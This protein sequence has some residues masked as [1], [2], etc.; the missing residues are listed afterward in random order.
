VVED[1][2]MRKAMTGWILI[3][4]CLVLLGVG[5]ALGAQAI[6][7]GE[8]PPERIEEWRRY[9]VDI[10][11]GT[12][13]PSPAVTR[14]LTEAAIAQ[15]AYASSAVALMRLLGIGIALLGVFLGF[16]LLRHR[17]RQAEVPELPPTQALDS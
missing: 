4:G 17:R 13:T 12:R 16:D 15:S 3:A 6:R 7:S 8:I 9:A 2:I 14:A 1:W 11:R 10:E 5:A